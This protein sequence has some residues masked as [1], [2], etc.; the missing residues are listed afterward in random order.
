[1]NNDLRKL[2]EHIIIVFFDHMTNTWK[3]YY[4]YYFDWFWVLAALGVGWQNPHTRWHFKHKEICRSFSPSLSSL[5]TPIIIFFFYFFN[6]IFQFFLW[7][8]VILYFSAWIL[9]KVRQVRYICLFVCLS[10]YFYTFVCLCVYLSVC[11]F[12]YLS[13]CL[14]VCVSVCQCRCLSVCKPV[15]VSFC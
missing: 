7:K 15:V 8:L 13:V 10:L 14:F 5:C 4:Y 11:L 9:H 12:V 1:M 3:F 6:F 2:S